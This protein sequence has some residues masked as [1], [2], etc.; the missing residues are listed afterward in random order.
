MLQHDEISRFQ[1][2]A[3]L[4][5]RLNKSR[6]KPNLKFLV[7]CGTPNLSPEDQTVVQKIVQR[8]IL[9]GNTPVAGLNH[10]LKG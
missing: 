10:Q 6:R 9:T 7:N 1:G 3:P 4:A 5:S 2:S 8:W